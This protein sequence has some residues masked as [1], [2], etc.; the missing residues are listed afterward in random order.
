M[1]AGKLKNKAEIFMPNEAP[2]LYGEIEDVFVSIGV[3]ACSATTKPRRESTTDETVISKTEFD[4]RFRY[5][6]A[7]DTLPRSA[8][9]L[10]NGMKLEILTVAN[11]QLN[12]REIQMICEERS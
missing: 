12:N 5:Y 8:F 10:L 6:T 9:V 4:L 7:L 3:F 1:R 11:V 2:N